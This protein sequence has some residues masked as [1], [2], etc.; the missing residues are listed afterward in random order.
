[1]SVRMPSRSLIT[2]ATRILSVPKTGGALLGTERLLI[3]TERGALQT[4]YKE[5][6]QASSSCDVVSTTLN[7]SAAWLK[8]HGF[9][10]DMNRDNDITYYVV[11]RGRKGVD[12]ITG[13]EFAFT[14]QNMG[15]ASLI[16]KNHYCVP[17]AMGVS[18]GEEKGFAGHLGRINMQVLKAAANDSNESDDSTNDDKA[19][20]GAAV[21]FS[22]PP[23]FIEY[24]MQQLA[25]EKPDAFVITGCDDKMQRHRLSEMLKRNELRMVRGSY[26]SKTGMLCFDEHESEVGYDIPAILMKWDS[27]GEDL[28]ID[29]VF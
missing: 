5:L 4:A 10:M 7:T 13:E 29:E 2:S 14:V 22:G 26:R 1:M 11:G 25:V 9:F 27:D 20:L 16:G 19:L 28:V 12:P 23:S 3:S 6:F 21:N 17:R 24:Q 18:A 8:N 15:G